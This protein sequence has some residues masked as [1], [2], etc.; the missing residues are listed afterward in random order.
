MNSNQRNDAVAIA[1]FQASGDPQD[2]EDLVSRHLPSVHGLAF[3]MTANQS[4]ADD[5]AQDVFVK[6]IGKAGSFA[7]NS[8]FSTWLYRVTLNT[9]FSWMDRQKK[10]TSHPWDSECQIPRDRSPSGT[11]EQEAMH[12]ELLTQVEMAL[13]KL[14]PDLRAAIVLTAMQG[15]SPKEAAEVAETTTENFYWRLH[16]ARKQLKKELGTYLGLRQENRDQGK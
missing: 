14:K 4:A 7:G 11:P 1:K 13:E 2:L 8:E 9:V 10:N 12:F 16:K 3:R 15:L 6:V 5:I